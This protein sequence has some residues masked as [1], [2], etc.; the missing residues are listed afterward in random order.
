MTHVRSL[1][2]YQ[3]NKIIVERSTTM[4]YTMK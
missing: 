3:I 2:I 4:H 1:Q